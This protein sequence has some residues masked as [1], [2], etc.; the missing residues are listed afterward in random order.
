MPEQAVSVI[1]PT[2]NSSGTL[3]WALESV[4]LQDW[5][6]YEVWVIGD[7]CTDDSE[8]IV[9]SF[10][11]ARLH[12]WNLPSNSGTPSLP[13]N[14]ALRRAR[15]RLVAYLGHDDLWFPWHLSDLVHTLEAINADLVSS[16]GIAVGIDG[17]VDTFGLP[18]DPWRGGR[19]LSPSTWLHRKELVDRIGLWSERRAIAHD[20]EFLQRVRTARSRTTVCPRVTALKF[21]AAMWHLYDPLSRP[22]QGPYLAALRED[23]QALRQLLLSEVSARA[24]RTASS[25]LT[26]H[27]RLSRW[28]LTVRRKGMDLYGRQ[29]WPLN[30]LL[31]RYWRRSAGL[32]GRSDRGRH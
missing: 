12:W 6:N 24:E 2:F 5:D 28:L 30:E 8:T 18:D 29:R 7:G 31:H 27:N 32:D 21:P 22:P 20:R 9:A 13:R 16:L 1:I 19:G 23:P 3:R 26:P 10:N 4:L 14:E 25:P 17:A 15:G 11:D